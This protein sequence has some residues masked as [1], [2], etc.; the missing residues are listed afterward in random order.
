MIVKTKKQ[1][2]SYFNDDTLGGYLEVLL[3]F[4][5][6]LTMEIFESS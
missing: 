4:K 3:L 2:F 5:I 1:N 6:I